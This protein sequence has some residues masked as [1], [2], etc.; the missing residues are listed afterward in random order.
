MIDANTGY[1]RYWQSV[2]TV[3]TAKKQLKQVIKTILAHKNYEQN[4]NKLTTHLPV[5][6]V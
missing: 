1:C 6:Y 2:E 3:E 4:K 5:E